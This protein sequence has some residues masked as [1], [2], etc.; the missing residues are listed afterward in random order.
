M[1]I[2]LARPSPP[3][4]SEA[5]SLLRAIEDRG[6][7]SNFGPVNTRFE[8]EMLD[9]MFGGVGACMTVCNATIGLM[10]AVQHAIKKRPTRRR[11][12]LMPSFT[13]AA[14]AH[15]A[16]WCGL[17]PLL[18]DIDEDTW[19]ASP[20]AEAALH[21]QY[22][23]DI[24]VIMPYAT[25]GYD[26]DLGRY[27]A[28][29]QQ[30]G[31]PVVVDAAASLGTIQADGRGFGTGFTGM[32]VY[33]MHATKSFA[34]GEGG[35][36]YSADP[37]VVANL[38]TM[39]NFGFGRPRNATMAG[40]NGKLTE[41]GALLGQLRLAGYDS[42]MER[43]EVLMH[44]YRATL[45]DLQF[46]QPTTMR[47]AHQFAS[48]L[49]PAG[50]QAQRSSIQAAMAT[51]GIGCANYFSPHLAEQDYFVENAISGPLPVTSAIANRML[52]LPLYDTMSEDEVANVAR[53]LR[54]HISAVQLSGTP[55][56]SR[57]NVFA[58]LDSDHAIDAHVAVRVQ[59][60]VDS[61]HVA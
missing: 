21:R 53:S 48:V 19:S 15:A 9:K 57:P 40:L 47:Q 42:V 29:S 39:C 16:M 11:Y 22:G 45:P 7:F 31:I 4:L 1:T 46:Q 23:D 50:M 60:G 25:F 20:A 61:E 37:S 59:A 55:P 56:R 51:E 36:I 17:T 14:A 34:T 13:F 35:L 52:S 44:A 10:L 41:T 8:A 5:P 49:L 28:L 12:A 24:A 43:R 18:C 3:R 26:I 58:R 33:S 30:Y 54:H 2:P 32:V 27:E 6:V 38:R